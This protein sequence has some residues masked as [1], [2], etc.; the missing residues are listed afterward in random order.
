MLTLTA[1]ACA[2][3]LVAWVLYRVQEAFTA[4]KVDCSIGDQNGCKKAPRLKNWWPLGIDR[5]IQIWTADA[6]QRLMD[7]F[8][9]HFRDVGTT[10]E[11]KFLGTIAFGTIEP[12][13]LEAMMLS[14]EK[15]FGFG[16]RR[17]IFFPLLG[18][19]IFTQE[20]EPWRH[21]RKM[22]QPQFGKQ[23]YNGLEI[24]QVHIDNLLDRIS[25]KSDRLDLQSLFFQLTLDTTTEYLF[26]RSINS[27]AGKQSSTGSNFAEAFEIAQNYVVQRFR[28]LDLYWMIG[29][30][31]FR[32]SCDTVHRFMDSIIDSRYNKAA[33]DSEG[34]SR[35]GLFDAIA[36]SSTDRKALRAQLLNVLLAGR[37]T[38][39]C[40]LTWTFYHLAQHP[41]VLSRLNKEIESKL[42]GRT[43]FTRD[44]LKKLG[45]LENVLKE[46]LRLYPSVPV[47]TRTAHRTTVLPVGGGPNQESPVLVRKG[48]NVA[49]CV[50]AMHRRKDLYGPDA[51]TFRPER[52]EDE[53]L[54]LFQNSLSKQWGYLP[55]NGGPRVCLGQDFAL[56]EASCTVIR[57]LQR[58][59]KVELAMEVPRRDWVGWSSHKTEGCPMT[60]YERQK[61]TLVLSMKE[62]CWV[63]LSE[64]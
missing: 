46:I 11:Q 29:G 16:L 38:T 18:D 24:F 31:K 27:L 21:S 48:E 43:D 64:S 32:N 63:K 8:T 40:L 23:Q 58:Y 4:Y 17:Q 13:N 60:A 34:S 19:G 49:F 52:W 30:K 22:L 1:V 54:P 28:L 26:G 9:F 35:Y 5:L 47:N 56:I 41:D 7:L 57:I 45:Y 20:G 37:D 61:M 14:Q 2:S 59:P 33:E 15:D 3:I 53:N 42:N 12:R 44:D 36:E 6:D 25:E 55:F 50:Y 10:L 39:A 62:G 51:E